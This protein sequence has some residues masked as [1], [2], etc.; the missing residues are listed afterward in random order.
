MCLHIP[1]D[2][3]KTISK[4]NSGW[5]YTYDGII[6]NIDIPDNLLQDAKTNG[7]RI[8][9]SSTIGEGFEIYINNE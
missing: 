4:D 7:I 3:N 8:H 9:E 1:G 2:Y 5:I 6:V